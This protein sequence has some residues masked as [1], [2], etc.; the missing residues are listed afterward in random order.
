MSDKRLSI[1]VIG[2][3]ISGLTAAYLLHQ[4]HDIKV[5][6]ANSYIGGH[7][8]TIDVVTSKKTYSVD[9]GFIVFNERTYPN[10]ISLLNRLGVASQPSTMG[11]SVSAEKTGLEYSGTSISTLFAQKKNIVSPSFY[12][13][14][15]GILRFNREAP[16]LLNSNDD[17]ITLGEYLLSNNY[18]KEFIDHFIVPMGAAIWSTV[19]DKMMDFPAVTFI[20]FFKN[21]GMLSFKDRP[22]WRVIKGGSKQYVK[23]L[24]SG[25]QDSININTPIVS[26]RRLENGVDVETGNGKTERFDKVILAVH[27][28]QAL[29]MLEDPTDEEKRILSAIPYEENIAVLHTDTSVL[30]YRKKVWSS[31]NYHIWDNRKDK[32]SLTYNMNILQNLKSNDVFCVTLNAGDEIK[33]GKILKTINYHHPRF[34]VE[35]ILAQKEKHLISGE[36]NTYYCGAYWHYGFHEDGVNSALEVGKHFGVGL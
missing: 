24:I 2:T 8:N 30:P 36:N 33:P 17:L 6:E 18:S 25:F 31:W 20:R 32:V 28:D 11:F 34:T 15:K 21:H 1:A 35:S 23:K 26:I 5:F 10:F 29:N 9:T 19:S 16:K 7:T 27:S 3:G 13:M 14:L 12:R 22:Q 4:K